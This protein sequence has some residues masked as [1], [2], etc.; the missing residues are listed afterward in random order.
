MCQGPWLTVSLKEEQ[1]L[2]SWGKE[3]ANLYFHFNLYLKF[4]NILIFLDYLF[5]NFINKI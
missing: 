3:T 5:Y 1:E 2:G 4:V